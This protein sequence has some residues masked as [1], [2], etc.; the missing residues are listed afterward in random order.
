[1]KFYSL[2][3]YHEM[4][5]C[6]KKFAPIHD[7]AKPLRAAAFRRSRGMGRHNAFARRVV[8]SPCGES[9]YAAGR[10]PCATFR[11]KPA[12][13]L[14]LAISSQQIVQRGEQADHQTGVHEPDAP[15]ARL[16]TEARQPGRIE[17]AKTAEKRHVQQKTGEPDEQKR[18]GDL[19][20]IDDGNALV[21]ALQQIRA[22]DKKHQI[23]PQDDHDDPDGQAADQHEADHAAAHEDPVDRRIKQ[24]PELGH[25]VRA[26]GKLTVDPIGT[27]R[28]REHERGEQ[29]VAVEQQHHVHRHHTQPDKGDD[30][31][32]GEDTIGDFFGFLS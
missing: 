9:R 13:L 14:H 20:G 4:M 31:G 6:G 8:Q 30:V 16:G 29:I 19:A 32:N 3:L 18:G 12:G 26:T 24:L 28:Q 25:A 11:L 1:M 7:D 15:G 2:V 23:T 21:I 27:R 10:S 5:R 22:P 17:P